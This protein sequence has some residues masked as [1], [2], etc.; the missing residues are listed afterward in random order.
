MGKETHKLKRENTSATPS[1]GGT[2]CDLSK[3]FL[4][5]KEVVGKCGGHPLGKKKKKLKKASSYSKELEEK[6]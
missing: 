4:S 3:S 2:L 6:T 1:Q 5:R